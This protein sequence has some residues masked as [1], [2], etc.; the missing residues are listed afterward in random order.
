[1]CLGDLKLL[2]ERA[3]WT[4]TCD[5]VLTGAVEA[6]WVLLGLLFLPS[7]QHGLAAYLLIAL[8][9]FSWSC[10]LGDHMCT[11]ACLYV[12]GW[13]SADVDLQTDTPGS[14]CVP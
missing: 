6:V 11:H 7:M 14:T 5:A 13:P 8:A 2:Q 1:M 9:A 4:C 3:T 10:R 12:C